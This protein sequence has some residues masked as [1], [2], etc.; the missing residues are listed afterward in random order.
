[1]YAPYKQQL[2]LVPDM[3]LHCPV[4]ETKLAFSNGPNSV[5]IQLMTET[6]PGSK[7]CLKKLKSHP[8]MS[9]I[10]AMFMVT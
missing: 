9:K 3:G 8:T 2:P 7:R 6:D 1:M 10:I 5:E 4:I